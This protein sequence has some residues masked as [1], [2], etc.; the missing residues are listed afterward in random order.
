MPVRD[1][2][3]T[4]KEGGAPALATMKGLRFRRFAP[5]TAS[6]LIHI[7]IVGIV[8]LAPGTPVHTPVLFA[9]LVE[10]DASA[11]T[12]CRCGRSFPI[13]ARSACRSPSRRRCPCAATSARGRSRKSRSRKLRRWRPRRRPRPS[14][15]RL[16]PCHPRRSRRPRRAASRR[17]ARLKSPAADP[18]PGAFAVAS[19]SQPASG[20]T[21]GRPRR[22]RPTGPAVAALPTDGITQRAIPAGRLPVPPGVSLQRAA[23]RRSGHHAAAT[24]SS[25]TTAAWPTSSSRNQPAIPISTRPRPTPCVAGA[26]SRR[27]A[28]RRQVAMWVQL[29]VEFRLR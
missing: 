13:A 25:P 7:G 18:G 22:R 15:H 28:G 26:S 1:L 19:P 8:L 17:A 23:A 14:S 27:G 20:T 11:A 12:A 29:P 5:V 6:V 24:C 3:Q 16:R 21:P 4:A 10:P 2:A 9:E